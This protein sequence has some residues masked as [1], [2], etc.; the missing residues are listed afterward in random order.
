MSEIVLRP[1]A[2][3]VSG[4]GS[5]A[6][7]IMVPKSAATRAQIDD[8]VV[9][10]KASPT[11]PAVRVSWSDLGISWFAPIYTDQETPPQSVKVSYR[12]TTWQFI[13]V[14]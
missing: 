1:F 12:D 3:E 8:L 4:D 11:S 7:G 2:A 14:D 6:M 13:I 10:Y 5:D 9:T